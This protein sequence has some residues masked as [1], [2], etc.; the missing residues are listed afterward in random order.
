M[1]TYSELLPAQKSNKAG[2]RWV[3]MTATS[4]ALSIDSKRDSAAYVVTEV[5]A[6]GHGREFR[7]DCA[8][9]QSDATVTAYSV[10]CGFDGSSA[11]NCKGYQYGK[12]KPCKHVLAAQAI[13]EN[14][15]MPSDLVNA[16][17]DVG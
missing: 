14:G 5:P 3:P 1:P 8:G 10:F 17:A 7:F 6:R 15:W 2:I 16:D 4:G 9:G 13:W 11:C 12:G